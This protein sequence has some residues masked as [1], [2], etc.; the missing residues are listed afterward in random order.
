MLQV[1]TWRSVS[2]S[3]IPIWA[4]WIF[5]SLYFSKVVDTKVKTLCL[6]SYLSS[7]GLRGGK[8]YICW[9]KYQNNLDWDVRKDIGIHTN[10]RMLGDYAFEFPVCCAVAEAM[11]DWCALHR[12][13]WTFYRAL[14]FILL[15][16]P[17]FQ[18][19][20]EAYFANLWHHDHWSPFI[21][22]FSM[23]K[24]KLFDMSCLKNSLCITT[25]AS[26]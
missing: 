20:Y 13:S 6:K 17:H 12:L 16:N 5:I 11:S 22:R 7:K 15:H 24:F 14:H 21:C 9:P 8:S 23:W 18:L 10:C 2:I 1:W 3:W 26:L 25:C 4:G 19:S